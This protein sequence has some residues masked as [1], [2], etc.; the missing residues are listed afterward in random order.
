MTLQ[1]AKVVQETALQ[2]RW[3]TLVSTK[4]TT[5]R[6]QSTS[7]YMRTPI[8][9][10]TVISRNGLFHARSSLRTLPSQQKQKQKH[11]RPRRVAQAAQRLVLPHSRSL[12]G[13]QRAHPY[14]RTQTSR[15]H[16]WTPDQRLPTTRLQQHTGLPPMQP[17]LIPVAARPGAHEATEAYPRTDLRTRNGH[18]AIEAIHS[19][20]RAF[21]STRLAL[22]LISSA[23][24]IKGASTPSF[25]MDN[26]RA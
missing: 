11:K 21:H 4:R 24:P 17:I 22:L 6:T 1:I 7:R 23:T 14:G 18:L 9:Q 26:L 13:R 8:L 25:I 16:C 12:R 2:R 20:A 5:R 10:Q 15:R 3:R 19:T